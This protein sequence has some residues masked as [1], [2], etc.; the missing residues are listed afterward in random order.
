MRGSGI[1][2]AGVKS[3]NSDNLNIDSQTAHAKVGSQNENSR[4][5][6]LRSQI[7]Y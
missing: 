2:T 4:E 6:E 7:E 3:R 5:H 1:L